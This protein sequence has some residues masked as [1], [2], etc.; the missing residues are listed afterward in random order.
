MAAYDLD[1]VDRRLLDLLQEDARYAAIDLA[2]AV[3]VSDNTIHNRMQRLEEAGVI[4]GYTTTVD[5]DRAG[6]SLYFHFTCTARI[7]DRAEVAEEV[8]AIPEVVEVTELMTGQRNLHVRLVA[9]DDED[10]TRL[11]RQLDE[12]AL[13]ID[14][15]NLVREERR[16]P[17]DFVEVGE[18]LDREE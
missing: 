10:I 14:D 18:M 11:A 15:E 16:E 4:T 5:H 2:E 8:M 7:S 1:D 17:L 6:L 9:A 12:L 13:E 3:G